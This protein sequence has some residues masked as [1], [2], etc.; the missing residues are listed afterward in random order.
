MGYNSV[1][2]ICNDGI[3]EIEKDPKG[4]FEKFKHT[5]FIGQNVD[6]NAQGSFGFGCHSNGFQAVYQGHADAQALI[7]VGGNYAT[8][9]HS[10]FAGNK[11]HHD[12]EDKVRLLRNWA[13][14]MGYRIVK[15]KTPAKANLVSCKFCHK[16][17]PADTAHLHDGEWVGD[18]CCWDERLR[19][20]E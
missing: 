13:D 19:A 4:F 12:E 2:F 3:G 7:A 18:E 8:V 20:T 11:G 6:K 17:V 14:E 10:E 15:K 9:V 1:L 16:S 5:Q